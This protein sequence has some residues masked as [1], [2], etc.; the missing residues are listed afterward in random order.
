MLAA[1]A[2]VMGACQKGPVSQDPDPQEQAQKEEKVIRFWDVVGQLVAAS[3]ITDDYQGKTFEPVIGVQDA[4]NPQARIV[5]TN[6]AAAAAKSFANLVDVD[7][8]NENTTTYTW[9]K[10]EI[11]TLTYTK[12]DGSI[13][14]APVQNHLPLGAAGRHQC[15]LQRQCLLPFWRCDWHQQG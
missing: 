3:D 8:I 1:V 5:A 15:V 10:D 6:S 12:L 4:S 13:R 7:T 2:I 14:P 9:T 11:G